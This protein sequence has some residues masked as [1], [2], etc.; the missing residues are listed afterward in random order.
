VSTKGLSELF[1]GVSSDVGLKARLMAQPEQVLSE[2]DLSEG[3]KEAVRRVQRRFGLDTDR[4]R[5]PE[6]IDPLIPWVPEAGEKRMP[7]ARAL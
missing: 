3:E 4:L 5:L 2:F 7:E 6:S 1:A